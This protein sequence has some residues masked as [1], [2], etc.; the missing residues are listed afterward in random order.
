MWPC[1]TAGCQNSRWPRF[2]LEHP[3]RS[4]GREHGG[5]VPGAAPSTHRRAVCQEI[6]PAGP[7]AGAKEP[8]PRDRTGGHRASRKGGL[9]Q[10]KETWIRK[11]VGRRGGM[12][13][14]GARAAAW[15][16]KALERAEPGTG[17]SGRGR[18]ETQALA[19]GTS[20][21]GGG[22][23]GHRAG[24]LGCREGSC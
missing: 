21:E 19:Q 12:R 17:S 8:V 18:S 24:V 9:R 11:E 13:K 4:P 16:W 2:G 6:L 14:E 7:C 10:P 3:P 23:W 22:F 20:G 1:V 15:I 5:N